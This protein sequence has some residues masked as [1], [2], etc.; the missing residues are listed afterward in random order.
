VSR[1]GATA[2]PV[3]DGSMALQVDWPECRA[4]GLCAELLPEHVT[5]DEWGYPVVDSRVPPERVA[6]A[7]AAVAACPRHAL[8]L[9]ET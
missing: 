3:V 2:R 4:R 9:R 7:R 8:H 6:L 1:R 5:I